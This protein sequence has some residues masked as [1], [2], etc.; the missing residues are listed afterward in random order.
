MWPFIIMKKQHISPID[1][2]E[3]FSRIFMHTLQLMKV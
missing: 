1:E 3:V 2:Y